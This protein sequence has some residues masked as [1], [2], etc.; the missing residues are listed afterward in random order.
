M[1]SVKSSF[2]GFTS[3]YVYA[4]PA[5]TVIF[6]NGTY[7]A[8]VD[9]WD[10]YSA[11]ASKF[12]VGTATQSEIATTTAASGSTVATAT[13]LGT[14]GAHYGSAVSSVGGAGTAD[15]NLVTAGNHTHTVTPSTV[16]VSTEM[17]PISTTIT[18]LRT[19]TEQKFF[20]ANTIHINGTNL[21]SGSQKLAATSDRYISGGSS[22]TDNAAATHTPTFTV[23]SYSS[24]SHSHLQYVGSG[25]QMTGA[26]SG[27]S[28]P[29]YVSTSST[30]HSHV[31]TGSASITALKG[32]LLKLWIAASRQ[33]PQNATIVMYCGNLSLLPPYW[34]VCDGANGTIDMQG[35]FLGYATSSATA[36]GAITSASTTYATTVPTAASDNFTHAHFILSTSIYS[37]LYIPHASTSFPHTHTVSGATLTTDAF[38][39]NIKLAFIQLVI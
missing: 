14:A 28:Q 25:A 7:S 33:I 1:L 31:L 29:A 2:G 17:R 21:V 9:G 27:T 35:Y 24:G 6:Y 20:P 30:T 10:I 12:I 11:A 18:M 32:K 23:S 4:I 37:F 5:D 39:A 22:V 38:P 36:H 13:G 8:A 3:P 34:K 19:A 16:T 26:T 15:S